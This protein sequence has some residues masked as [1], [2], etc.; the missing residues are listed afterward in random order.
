MSRTDLSSRTC[1]LARA[2][3]LV[4]D[5]WT[6]MILR[7]LFLGNR[8]FDDVLRQSGMSSHLLSQR[9]KKLEAEGVIRRQ[10]YSDRPP[11][12]EYLLTDMG[13]ELWPVIV[14]MKQWGDRWLGDGRRPFDIV[15]KACGRATEPRMAC[16]ECGEPMGARDAEV[17]LSKTLDRERRSAGRQQRQSQ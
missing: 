11:R 14:A 6:F 8:R 17:R 12:Y 10:A 5:A 2:T 15:H 3:A 13:L 7:E 4:G 1:T 16:S 9:L